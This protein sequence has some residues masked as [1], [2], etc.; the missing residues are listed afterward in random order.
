MY[1]RENRRI[2]SDILQLTDLEDMETY[3][4]TDFEK[5]FDSI[6]RDFLFKSLS[7]LNFGENFISC[8][9][10]TCAKC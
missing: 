4:N 7:T 9:D 8:L 5:A 1:I 3:I 10:Q 6:E 2:L